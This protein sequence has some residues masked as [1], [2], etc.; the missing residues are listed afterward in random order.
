MLARAFVIAGAIGLSAPAHAAPVQADTP[1][2]KIPDELNDVLRGLMDEMRPALEDA[3][4]MFQSLEAIDD[5][6]NYDLPEF[7][8]NGDIIIRRKPDAPPYQP[9]NR[10]P[11]EAEE[12]I[13]L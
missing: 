2:F 8:P 13:K 5:P 1:Q 4:R 9:K 11:D 6:R 7:L 3:I 10:Q 12:T